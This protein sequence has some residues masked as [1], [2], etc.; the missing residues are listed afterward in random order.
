MCGA[1]ALHGVYTSFCKFIAL[2]DFQDF[3]PHLRL[4]KQKDT[5]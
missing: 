1:L 3:L 4:L 2:Q 5:Y